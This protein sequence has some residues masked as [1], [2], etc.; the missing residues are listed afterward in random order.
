MLINGT[1]R[2]LLERKSERYTD[3]H[4]EKCRHCRR[5]SGTHFYPLELYMLCVC[6]LDH[7]FM[8]VCNNTVRA[9]IHTYTHTHADSLAHTIKM[10][11]SNS[12]CCLSYPKIG[13]D[14]PIINRNSK[15]HKKNLRAHFLGWAINRSKDLNESNNDNKK[16]VQKTRAVCFYQ[17]SASTHKSAI[18]LTILRGKM[19]PVLFEHIFPIYDRVYLTTSHLLC[20]NIHLKPLA[21]PSVDK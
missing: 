5:A 1:L 17:A 6:A 21:K 8:V 20:T 10:Y 19:S 2:K 4:A 12:F 13:E 11:A 16:N 9:S 14:D 15:Q 18:H 3:V 7:F